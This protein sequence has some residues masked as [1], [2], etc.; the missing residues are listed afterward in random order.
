[1][2]TKLL[3]TIYEHD[4]IKQAK[5]DSKQKY[6]LRQAARAVIFDKNNKIALLYVS[7]DNYHKLPGG[8]VKKDEDII[9]ALKRECLE[10]IGCNIKISKT[11]GKIVEYRDQFRQK[12]E[13]TC[14]LAH[15]IGPKGTPALTKQE[16]NWGFTTKW[17]SLNQALKLLQ[18]DKPTSYM[19][20]F[21]IKRDARFLEKIIK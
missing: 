13:S 9:K 6:I 8:G 2:K 14:Y 10:E 4:V 18:Q 11:I 1:M 12:Q 20:H 7:K 16:T 19:G 17:A 21:V 15:V 3:Q 5:S